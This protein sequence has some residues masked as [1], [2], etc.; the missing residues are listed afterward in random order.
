MIFVSRTT[1]NESLNSPAFTYT[2]HSLSEEDQQYR[3]F[4]GEGENKYGIF[5]PIWKAKWGKAPM[6]GIVRADN[7]FLAEKLAYDRGLNP[8]PSLPPKIKFLGVVTRRA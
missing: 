1:K 3:E 6:L 7:E 4:F 2:R 8:C 5:P